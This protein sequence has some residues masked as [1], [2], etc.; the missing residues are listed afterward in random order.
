MLCLRVYFVWL[1][2]KQ[3][4]N[5]LLKLWTKNLLK[6]NWAKWLE[7]QMLDPLIRSAKGN[8]EIAFLFVIGKEILPCERTTK[9]CCQYSC[10]ET[11]FVCFGEVNFRCGYSQV[12]PGLESRPLIYF[13]TVCSTAFSLGTT[14]MQLLYQLFTLSFYSIRF[15]R[16][17]RISTNNS[18]LRAPSYPKPIIALFSHYQDKEYV[19][20]FSKNL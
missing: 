1:S 15:E 5:R 20:S 7:Q 17:H 14:V 18:S 12:L 8:I 10:N 4:F 16:V 19:R 9:F 2:R 13:I 6:K 11:L 3:N